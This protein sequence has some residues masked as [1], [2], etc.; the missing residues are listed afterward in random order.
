MNLPNKHTRYKIHLHT[1]ERNGIKRKKK[2]STKFEYLIT[3]INNAIGI[4]MKKTWKMNE[5]TL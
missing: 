4:G 5:M 2:N 3:N 1:Q